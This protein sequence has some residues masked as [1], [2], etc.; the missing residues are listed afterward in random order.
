MRKTELIWYKVSDI[1][2]EPSR[3]LLTIHNDGSLRVSSYEKVLTWR[4]NK[5]SFRNLLSRF[6]YND[7]VFE[8]CYIEEY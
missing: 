5:Y 4:G 8:W 2:P 3:P 1:L 6:A 7:D